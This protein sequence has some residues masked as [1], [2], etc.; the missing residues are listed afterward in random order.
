[1]RHCPVKDCFGICKKM[2]SHLKNVH[3]MK[4]S[5]EYYELLEQARPVTY[6]AKATEANVVDY[7]IDLE[8]TANCESNNSDCNR[9]STM[10]LQS[11]YVS[12]DMPEEDASK[13]QS[14]TEGELGKEKRPMR[15]FPTAQKRPMWSFPTAQKMLIA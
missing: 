7:S 3:K 15:P 6:N 11:K 14:S 2:S 10:D 4:K 1:M 5:K 8:V 13:T 12:E 9:D